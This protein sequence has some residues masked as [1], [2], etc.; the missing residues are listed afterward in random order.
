MTIM[1][2]GAESAL[3]AAEPDELLLQRMLDP[4]DG[5]D[6]AAGGLHPEHEA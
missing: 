4:F 6:L 5:D 1:P 2:G 3:C